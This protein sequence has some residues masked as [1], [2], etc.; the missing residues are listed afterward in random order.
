MGPQQVAPA[1]VYLAHE[2]CSLNGETLSVGR[3][4]RSSVHGGDQ[5]CTK[6]TD[7]ELVAE[8]IEEYGRRRLH[9]ARQRRPEIDYFTNT[10]TLKRANT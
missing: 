6:K 9:G 5:G 2:S 8:R 4:S 1:V 10:S 7:L 3:Q